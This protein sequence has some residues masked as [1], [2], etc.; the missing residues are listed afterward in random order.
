MNRSFIVTL[1]VAVLP[2]SLFSAEESAFGAGDLEN[3]TPYGLTSSEKVILKNKESL[4]KVVVKL[5]L[6]HI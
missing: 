1:L 3:P 4:H 5:S 6:I 2:Y